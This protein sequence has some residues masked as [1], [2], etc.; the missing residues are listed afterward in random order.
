MGGG[1]AGGRGRAEDVP[2]GQGPSCLQ[3]TGKDQVIPCS[4]FCP[5]QAHPAAFSQGLGPDG[6]APV[7]SAGWPRPPALCPGKGRCCSLSCVGYLG[8]G[9]QDLCPACQLWHVAQQLSVAHP[10]PTGWSQ[11]CSEQ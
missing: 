4:P 9:R 5:G 6:R 10:A 2:Q 7:G 1:S 3:H 8:Q 11:P